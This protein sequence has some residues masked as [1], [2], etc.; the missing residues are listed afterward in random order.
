MVVRAHQRLSPQEPNVPPGTPRSSSHTA[1]PPTSTTPA[2]T[3][4]TMMTVRIAVARAAEPL[5]VPTRPSSLGTH[6]ANLQHGRRGAPARDRY[7]SRALADHGAVPATRDRSHLSTTA[8]Q[9]T[10]PALTACEGSPGSE[11]QVGV[12]GAVQRY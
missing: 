7:P 2:D 3:P 10:G 12:T 9:R 11:F 4:E 1:E 5:V 8:R 6:C